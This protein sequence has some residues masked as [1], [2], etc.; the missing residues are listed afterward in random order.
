MKIKISKFGTITVR[1]KSYRCI[2]IEESTGIGDC[3]G[4]CH[5]N[6]LSGADGKLCSCNNN[7]QP[8]GGAAA[9]SYFAVKKGSR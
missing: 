4:W 3:E 8:D 5:I 7:R 9:D 2:V 1:K 6:D